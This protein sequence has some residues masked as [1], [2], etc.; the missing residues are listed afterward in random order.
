M[1]AKPSAGPKGRKRG[2]YAEGKLHSGATRRQLSR[3]KGTNVPT[4]ESAV[5]GIPERRTNLKRGRKY[6][7][8]LASNRVVTITAWNP[9][10]GERTCIEFLSVE[11]MIRKWR[12]GSKECPGDSCL[13]V[14]AKVEG[15]PVNT[16]TYDF[17]R[18]MFECIIPEYED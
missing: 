1:M 2:L 17:D 7:E 3:C 10:T 6:M 15:V 8:A 13:I 18:F 11:D 4:G 9:A 5:P 16:Y 12:A 14:R